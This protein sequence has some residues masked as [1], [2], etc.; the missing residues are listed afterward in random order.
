MV[1]EMTA[2]SAFNLSQGLMMDLQLLL[3]KAVQDFIRGDIKGFYYNLKGIKL[4][5][6]F[7][8]SKEERNELKQLE[9][10]ISVELQKLSVDNVGFQRIDNRQIIA[11]RNALKAI[12]DYNEKILD[13]LDKY[14]LLLK[15]KE[16][17]TKIT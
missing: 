7:S 14:D 4:M 12:E 16:D 1:E 3:N 5:F 15:R 11:K 13:L 17:R 6:S 9:Q 2:L 10:K 8:F